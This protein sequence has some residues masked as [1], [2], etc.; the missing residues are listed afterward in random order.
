MDSV[1]MTNHYTYMTSFLSSSTLT[2]CL[3]PR[4]TEWK[5][6]CDVFSDILMPDLLKISKKKSSVEFIFQVPLVYKENYC[7]TLEIKC[8]L[9]TFKNQSINRSSQTQWVM[10]V[11]RQQYP[12]VAF[13][14]DFSNSFHV[15]KIVVKYYWQMRDL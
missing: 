8:L 15:K 12:I 1:S 7:K 13:F 14:L 2:C 5:S 4:P 9:M 10:S 3:H 6:L 11:T